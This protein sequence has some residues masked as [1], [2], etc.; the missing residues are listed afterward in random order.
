MGRGGCDVRPAL[1]DG[2]REKQRNWRTLIFWNIEQRQ[3]RRNDQLYQIVTSRHSAW[4]KT[5]QN[6]KTVTYHDQHIGTGQDT[7]DDNVLVNVTICQDKTMSDVSRVSFSSKIRKHESTFKTHFIVHCQ[8]GAESSRIWW[9]LV[10]LQFLPQCRLAGNTSLSRRRFY[11]DWSVTTFVD[12]RFPSIHPHLI[13]NHRYVTRSHC[14]VVIMLPTEKRR[15]ITTDLVNLSASIKN[16]RHGV[17]R[18]LP[19]CYP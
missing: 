2:W 15:L 14:C 12:C 17:G 16:I 18:K 4:V 8:P 1:S 6:D 19:V 5:N 11:K 3:Q 9:M 13:T 7:H 10:V